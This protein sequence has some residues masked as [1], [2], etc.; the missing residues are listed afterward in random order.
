TLRMRPFFSIDGTNTRPE[1]TRFCP[2]SSAAKR[3]GGP[4]AFQR[5]HTSPSNAS[6]VSGVAA[7]LDIGVPCSGTQLVETTSTR[8]LPQGTSPRSVAVV[9]SPPGPMTGMID[10]GVAPRG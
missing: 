3:G 9:G 4:P 1:T 8:R 7:P 6:V 5:V 2:K 10:V